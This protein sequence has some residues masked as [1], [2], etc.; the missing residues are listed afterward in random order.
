MNSPSRSTGFTLGRL[1]LRCEILSAEALAGG[2]HL[3]WL[4]VTPTSVAVRGAMAEKDLRIEETG[5]VARLRVRNPTDH[6][7]LI[8]ADWILEG[9][10]QSR[11]VDRSVIVGAA[12][13]AELRVRCVEKRRWAP[14]S[15]EDA[16]TFS[17]RGPASTATRSSFIQTRT[18]RLRS[19]GA[20]ATDQEGVWSHVRTELER[21]STR[22]RTESYVDF[23]HGSH[24]AEVAR[25]EALVP[26]IP[27]EA[28]GLLAINAAGRGWFEALP[29]LDELRCV[30][31]SVLGGV[32]SSAPE[33]H[34]EEGAFHAVQRSV[35][36]LWAA[37]LVSVALPPGTLGEHLVLNGA[38]AS[39]SVVLFAG[40]VAHIA[41]RVALGAP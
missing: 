23:L 27:A 16:G 10:K 30:A 24:A 18:A 40:E 21:T 19:G 35:D 7:V 1:G 5:V 11:V 17:M 37:D 2:V 4:R 41:A 25:A 34:V 15:K 14:R 36:A 6:P 8:P 32:M 22:S 13:S 39:G 28:N 3:G 33:S 29:G 26:S 31:G 38:S 9:G 12:A 20:Y